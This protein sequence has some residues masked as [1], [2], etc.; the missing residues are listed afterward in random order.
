MNSLYSI[1]IPIHN[2]LKVLPELLNRLKHFSK[3]GHEVLIINDGSTD[4][5]DKILNK[6]QHINRINIK[7]NIG[8]GGALK[9]GLNKA[10]NEKI[11]IFDGD[12]EL[13]PYDINLLMILSKENNIHCVFG[14]RF[15]TRINISSLWDF[16]NFFF[17]WFFNKI[18]ESNLSDALCC[19][20]A[21]YKKDIKPENLVSSKFDIDVELASTLIKKVKNIRMVNINYRRRTMNEGKKL[22]IFDSW[23]IIKRI[24]RS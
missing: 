13:E 22:H 14:S 8:K 4:G 24:L 2:E 3:S 20:K 9:T 6:C 10:L 17:T 5:T 7:T 19:A 18:H 1:I 23:S 15:K 21:F 16:G 12:M 11:I